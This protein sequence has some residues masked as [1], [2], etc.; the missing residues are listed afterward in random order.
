MVL[1]YSYSHSLFP[2][3]FVFIF[4]VVDSLKFSKANHIIESKANHIIEY[5]I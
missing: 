3:I 2:G 1:F 5:S 4:N